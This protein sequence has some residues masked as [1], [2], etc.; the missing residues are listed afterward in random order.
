MDTLVDYIQWM[1]DFSLSTVPFRDADMLVL[2]ALSY[3]DYSPIFD[4]KQGEVYLKDCK[5]MIQAD[6]VEITV[7]GDVTGF[8]KILELAAN[9]RRFGELRMSDY[10]EPLRNDP[11]LQ[12]SAVCF[13][14]PRGLSFLVYRGTDST[15]A[16][17]KED[18][19][20]SFSR[21][22][23]QEHAL[24]YAEEHIT[25][26]RRW[27]LGGHSKGGNLAF[28]AACLLHKEK[29]QAVKH[30]YLLDGPGFDPEGMDSKYIKRID[31][32][33]TRIIPRFS[34]VGM[35]FE[36]QLS[37]SRIVL[38][39][40]S[41]FSQH[42]LSTWGIDHGK[43]ALAEENDP[44][45]RRINTA[46]A[47]WIESIPIG[48]RMTL[49]NDLFDSLAATGADRLDELDDK[50]LAGLVASLHTLRASNEITKT[51]LSD[52]LRRLLA[53]GLSLAH[54]HHRER[55]GDT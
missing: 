39:S 28:Y 3:V 37:D 13:H 43:L 16:G 54:F 36:P 27:I 52:L 20:I 23:A 15:L 46:I 11:P 2:C 41:G 44:I 35:L 17:W 38:S 1:G 14:G 40:A 53:E 5:A 21:T 49:V 26:D 19:M 7:A 10:V 48:N 22:E 33:T 45:S 50:G 42:S 30:V 4:G 25:P 9:S 32:R 51:A 29:W 47:G 55:N 31:A 6:Q 12:F 8:Q 18:F 24:R 34:I